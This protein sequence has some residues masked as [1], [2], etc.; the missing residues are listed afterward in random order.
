MRSTAGANPLVFLFPEASRM[1]TRKYYGRTAF[2]HGKCYKVKGPVDSLEDLVTAC[3]SMSVFYPDNPEEMA[4]AS[5]YLV[6][7]QRHQMWY[8]FKA[9]L[10][11]KLVDD[12]VYVSFD[13][14]IVLREN[15]SLWTDRHCIPWKIV[16][17]ITKSGKVIY[18]VVTPLPLT[19]LSGH[20]THRPLGARA[21]SYIVA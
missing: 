1:C 12:G 4:H 2:N 9:L 10:G 8:P 21:I 17:F 15:D 13:H 11:F 3:G 20:I 7:N 16:F 6:T 18:P 19:H 14:R 5:D